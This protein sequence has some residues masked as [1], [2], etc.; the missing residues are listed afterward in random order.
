MKKHFC[1]R[2]G[3]F[4]MFCVLAALTITG[5]AM[6]DASAAP[7]TE[8]VE[9]ATAEY[10]Q[11]NYAQAQRSFIQA[12]QSTPQDASLYRSLARTY[13][14]QNDYVAATAYYD[15]Y[16]R[17]A[18]SN[19]TDLEQVQ[20]ERRLSATRSGN[21]VWQ[22]S[23][24]QRLILDSLDDQLDDG[25]AYTP[26]G[27]G[28]WSLYQSLIRT[29]FAQ[30]ELITIKKRLVRRLFDEIEG[31]FVTP[32]DQPA[33][34]L[35]LD[36]WKT[37]RE[38]MEATRSLTNDEVILD[39]IDRRLKIVTA[40]ESLLLAR[41]SE[42]VKQAQAA[43]LENPDLVFPAWYYIA[44]LIHSAQYDLAL[45]AIDKLEARI[46]QTTPAQVNYVLI[47]RAAVLNKSG[48]HNSAANIYSG[49]LAP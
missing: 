29:N 31:R 8:L 46:E 10:N 17:L 49:I 9:Q 47:L 28:A 34:Q 39:A 22:L 19:A 1:K 6:P 16:L 33:P 23:D 44:A 5:T 25:R 27:G 36:D 41:Y 43:M 24:Q 14:W 32:V 20:G 45:A 30:P 3:R 11:G 21:Q 48:Q 12:I 18:A 37:Q 42:A 26:G 15:F 13:F 7:D 40:A 2:S 4:T 38:R 35:E